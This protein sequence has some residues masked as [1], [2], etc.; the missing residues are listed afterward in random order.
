LQALPSKPLNGCTVF[1]GF[2]GLA[3]VLQKYYV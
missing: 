2:E 1:L 3:P